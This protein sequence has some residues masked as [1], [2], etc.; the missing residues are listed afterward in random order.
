MNK[1]ENLR[2]Y[3]RIDDEVFLHV[4]LIDR[5]DIVDI[6][7]YFNKFRQSTILTA[8]FHQQRIAMAPV[9]KEIHARDAHISSYFSMLSDQVDLLANRLMTDSI[10][11]SDEP[12]QSVNLAAEGM[13]FHSQIEY[14]AGDLIE[15]IFVLFPGED[16]IPVL[17]EVVRSSWDNNVEE[18]AVSVK[19]TR[20][21]EDDKELLIHHILY[22][23]RQL[24]QQKRLT[25]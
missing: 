5:D 14:Q 4:K 2:N 17:A 21:N 24:L 19:Y 23:E 6:D 25:G 1:E 8:R 3:F 9:L 16:Y 7:K 12:L 15:R 18:Y 13:R 22:L 10:F 20:L 11:A